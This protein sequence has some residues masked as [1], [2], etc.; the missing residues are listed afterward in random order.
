MTSVLWQSGMIWIARIVNTS[1]GSP[2]RLCA[3]TLGDDL[4][5][6]LEG[7]VSVVNLRLSSP[8]TTHFSRPPYRTRIFLD[9]RL[10]TSP[11]ALPKPQP[12]YSNRLYDFAA[13]SF[14]DSSPVPMAPLPIETHVLCHVALGHL[15]QA[16]AAVDLAV[17]ATQRALGGG[18]A[19]LRL[20]G[21]QVAD[22]LFHRG[23]RPTGH[24]AGTCQ[25]WFRSG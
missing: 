5:R 2:L 22:V 14:A 24:L 10:R 7:M 3:A 12:L 23:V 16:C 25:R 6:E 4:V 15:L 21:E 11:V 1:L 8:L 18:L 13:L 20:P 17:D 9:R 19:A